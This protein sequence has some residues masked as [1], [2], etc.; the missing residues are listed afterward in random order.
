MILLQIQQE[1]NF[2]PSSKHPQDKVR[3]F[4]GIFFV[5]LLHLSL[6]SIAKALAQINVS[7]RV[8]GRKTMN[9]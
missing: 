7:K 1:N 9:S 2:L 5:R 4:L 8:A 6:K 3:R